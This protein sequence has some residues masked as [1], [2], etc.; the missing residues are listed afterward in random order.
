LRGGHANVLGIVHQEIPRHYLQSRMQRT[1]FVS[2]LS[3]T[4]KPSLSETASAV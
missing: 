4:M 1:A 3:S 2:G